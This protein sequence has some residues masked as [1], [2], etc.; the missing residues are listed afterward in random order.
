VSVRCQNKCHDAVIE[1]GCMKRLCGH[2]A[3][4]RHL[5][6]GRKVSCS[7]GDNDG[8]LGE[9]NVERSYL[10]MDVMARFG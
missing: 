3:G 4:I 9:G 8:M 6:Y 10:K 1:H 5:A 7:R 2:A